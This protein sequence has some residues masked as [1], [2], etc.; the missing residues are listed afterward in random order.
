MTKEET[1]EFFR[2]RIIDPGVWSVDLWY[3][4]GYRDYLTRGVNNVPSSSSLA[5]SSLGD[6]ESRAWEMGYNDARG[7]WATKE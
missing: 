2:R 7:D 4:V 5:P 6:P 3:C 1:M